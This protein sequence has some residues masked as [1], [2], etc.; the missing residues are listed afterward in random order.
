MLQQMTS[1]ITNTEGVKGNGQGGEEE[2]EHCQ[3][4][5]DRSKR[6]ERAEPTAGRRIDRETWLRAYPTAGT[7]WQEAKTAKVRERNMKKPRRTDELVAAERRDREVWI[8]AKEKQH[9]AVRGTRNAIAVE[10]NSVQD[11]DRQGRRRDAVPR[12]VQQEAPRRQ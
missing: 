12:R 8:T 6:N 11:E 5:A 3:L 4:Q 9:S 10:S 1:L 2:K 7:V